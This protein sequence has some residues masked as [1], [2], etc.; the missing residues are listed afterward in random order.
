MLVSLV[1]SFLMLE[2]GRKEKRLLRVFELFSWFLFCFMLDNE[3]LGAVV[4]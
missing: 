2:L 1:L 4:L 3:C